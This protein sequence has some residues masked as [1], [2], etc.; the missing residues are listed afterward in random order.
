MENPEGADAGGRPERVTA[1]VE[2]VHGVVQI[3]DDDGRTAG[4][5]FLIA[6]R[7]L[8]TCAH[9]LAGGASTAPNTPV[10]VRFPQLNDEPRRA[11]VSVPHWRRPGAGDVAFLQMADP[12]PVTAQPLPL[13][14][15]GSGRRPVKTYGFPT[16]AP[17]QGQFGYAVTGDRIRG[18][19]DVELLQ[20]TDCT[21]VTEGFSGAPVVDE[22]TGLVIGMVDSIASP[23]R[24]GRGRSTCY[25]TPTETLR[26]IHPDL[27][28]S[29]ICPY[30]GLRAFTTEDAAWFHG[31]EHAVAAVLASIDRHP[32]FVALLGP[33]GSGKSSLVRAGVRPALGR[34]ELPGSDRWYWVIARPGQDP[35][36]NL[37]QAGLPNAE[38]GLASAVRQW[39]DRNPDAGRLVLVLDQFEEL[40]LATA[41]EPHD[42][43]LRELVELPDREPAV[44]VLLTLR[45]DFY[46]RLAAAAPEMMTLVERGLVNV[47][48]RVEAVDL[49]AIVEQPAQAVGLTLEPGLT[50]RIARDAARVTEPSTAV[51]SAPTTVLPL[52]SS[53]LAE[54]WRR[55]ENGRL[56]HA[57]YDRIGGVTGWLDRWCDQ[58]Y[59]DACATLPAHRTPMARQIITALVRPGD[60]ATGVP[61]TRQRRTLDELRAATQGPNSPE[62]TAVV[63]VLADRRLVTTGRDP[64]TG[65]PVVELAHE[66]LIHQWAAL[67]H[68]LAD[69]HEF[70]TWRRGAEAAHAQWQASTK[71]RPGPDPELLLHGTALAAAV[72]WVDRRA[73]AT[74][75]DLAEYVRLSATAQQDRLRRERRRVAALA[76]LLVLAVLLGAFAF[77]QRQEARHQAAQAVAQARRADARRLA[78]EAGALADR[79]PD[80]AMLLALEGLGMDPGPDAWSGLASL[81][82]R[83]VAPSRVLYGHRATVAGVAVSPDGTLLASVEE[84]TLF[85]SG[86]VRLWDLRTGQQVKVLSDGPTSQAV[87]FSPN[88]RFLATSGS[89]GIALWDLSLDSPTAHRLTS[90]KLFL[91]AVA[92]SPD[93]RLLAGFDDKGGIQLWDVASRQPSGGRLHARSGNLVDL[94]FSPD[95]RWLV[96]SSEMGIVDYYDVSTRRIIDRLRIVQGALAVA[97]SP[98]GKLLAVGGEE[99]VVHLFSSDRRQTGAIRLAAPIRD[100]VF[101]PGR[102]GLVT[103]DSRGVVQEWDPTTRQQSGPDLV[104]H[105]GS[106]ET[107]AVSRDGS[108][109]VSAGEDQQVRLWSLTVRQALGAAIKVDAR[110]VNEV[111][112][113]PDGTRL[114]TAGFDGSIRL[115]VVANRRQVAG[116]WSPDG[117]VLDPNDV[118]SGNAP[119]Q[120]VFDPDGRSLT[121]RTSSAIY[122]W[123]IPSGRLLDTRPVPGSIDT[124]VQLAPD[125]ERYA[126]RPEDGEI[127]VREM[128]TGQ[129]VGPAQSG[130]RVSSMVFRSDGRQ[131]ATDGENL[132]QVRVWDV[133]S[134]EEIAQGQIAG[135]DP[136]GFNTEGARALAISSTGDTLLTVA[137]PWG[138]GARVWRRSGTKL[139]DHRLP[140]E[141]SVT[142]AAFSPN[143]RLFATGGQDRSVIFW[144]VDTAEPVSDPLTPHLSGVTAVAFSPDGELLASAS[145]DGT[146]RLWATPGTWIRHACELAGR[147]LSR[148]EWNRYLAGRPYVR[149]CAKQAAG[150]GADAK[151]P[152]A[153]YPPPS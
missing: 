102:P 52:L 117:K 64:V 34:A 95:G 27:R 32:P 90:R 77:V 62:A 149:T 86:D 11:W 43:L 144:D 132:G 139:R 7:L 133:T 61:A 85:R 140:D 147:N 130:K 57:A 106:V 124:L 26:A 47:P 150:Y 151:A 113:S 79:Q 35:Y 105:V 96:S 82:S 22:R 37:T 58:A 143:G 115:W 141:A 70:L 9:V 42:R 84:T 40:L 94:T 75:P 13:G 122:R 3:L 81:L 17:D 87:T 101:R 145:D 36:V 100:L 23:D 69:D 126:L 15:A 53:S 128:T 98:D 45:D 142:A 92:F 14:A 103:A 120:V 123:E 111:A 56:T 50:E 138:T 116:P 24:H 19:N 65:A 28:L 73:E 20:L 107:L 2:F 118:I 104:G 78:V 46:S 109:L 55:R 127:T 112:F 129:P 114:A 88:G 93:G 5:G 148:D 31:R 80:L 38:A 97:F 136:G 54:L 63:A 134:G 29:Q 152:V 121:S 83:P 125:G 18:D 72:D 108:L 71:G 33:S 8:V 59:A 10:L 66:A 131:V 89:D 4:A 74:P 39:R 6:D 16:T 21:E 67:R 91:G 60:E 49:A 1:S 137:D 135:D 99:G 119:R 153:T 25:V 48:A 12:A 41:E 68:W 51:G 76:G 44:T 146:V 30:P 110:R